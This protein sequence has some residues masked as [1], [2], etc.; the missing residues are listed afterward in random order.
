MPT[1]KEMKDKRLGELRLQA[2]VLERIVKR[3]YIGEETYLAVNGALE[4]VRQE[5]DK[6]F[7][8]RENH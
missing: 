1:Y 7:Y 5:A 2:E 6:I 3:L 8:H 4:E